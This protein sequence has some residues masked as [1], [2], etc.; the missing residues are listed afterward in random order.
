MAAMSGVRSSIVLGLGLTLGGLGCNNDPGVYGAFETT[1]GNATTST[2]AADTLPPTTGDAM[3]TTTAASTDDGSTSGD[4]STGTT[5]ASTTTTGEDTSGTTAGSDDATTTGEDARAPT[6]DGTT[7]MDLQSGVWPGSVVQITFS[8]PM[9]V[10]TVT[11]NVMNTNCSGSLQLSTDDFATC[12]PME[13][14]PFSSDDTAFSISP[15]GL[16]DSHTTYAIR[17]QPT[18]TD[19]AGNPMSAAFETATGFTSSY[20]RTIAIDGVNDF[21]ADETLG[22]TT[23]GHTAYMAWDDDYVYF[24]LASPDVAAG[25]D[26]VWWVAYLGGPMGTAQGVTYNTQSPA[27]PFSA[28]WH[29]RWRL[30][31]TFTGALEWDGAAWMPP[32]WTIN[33]VFASGDFV[34]FRVALIDLGVPMYLDTVLGL[35]RE[36]AFNEASWAGMPSSAYVDGYDPDFA[37]FMQFDLTGSTVPSAYVPM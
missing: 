11:T 37:T 19:A 7:P 22:T 18:V 35:L 34:E 8:E 9:D 15:V 14:A 5:D 3:D 12:V 10:A 33:D 29:A 31:G 23:D 4:S 21:T 6:V 13:G 28:R 16:L 26:Q 2:T 17:V 25:N 27:L 1:T 30:D 20:Y 32:S 24:G 36:Q